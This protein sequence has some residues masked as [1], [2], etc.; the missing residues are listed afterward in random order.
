MLDP[1]Q[2]LLL[3]SSW[4]CLENAGYNPNS[5]PGAIGIF[6]GASMNTYLINNCY[7]NRGQLDSNDQ[8]QPFTLDSMGGFQ[9]MVANDK[10]YLTTRISYKLNLRGPSV[11]IQTACST[12]LVVVHLAC[13]SLINGESDMALAG[14]ASIN[15][16]QKIGYLYQ[17]GLILSGDGHCR[18]FDAQAQG[19]IFGSGVGVV[20][21]KRLSDALADNDQIYAV[22]KG[23]AINNDGGT[24]LGFTA[25]GGEGQISVAAEALAFAGVDANTI[26]FIEAH[27]TG[28]TLG[29]PIEVDA[30]AKAYSAA[31]QGECA[32]GSVKTNIGHMQIASGIVGL[33]KATLALKHQIIPPTLHFQNPNPQIDFSKTPF[34]INTEA[35]PWQNKQQNGQE[36][37]R[38]AGVNSLGIGGVNA[39]II[40]EEA[41]AVI[42]QQNQTKPPIHLLT[43]SARNPTGFKRFS[44]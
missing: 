24:K 16:P 30:L 15:S 4:E 38:R 36:L 40:L 28:T 27:G 43:I 1:Q 20:L 8:L 34:Y 10:D 25:P 21:L 42:P 2:R 5:Y 31:N 17:E 11:N 14:A 39:H 6:A 12:G 37:P 22:I 32:L 29:D 18:A 26:S 41:P 33:I 7:P 44:Q 19:T 3:Q 13:Q 9:T 35:I 23:S